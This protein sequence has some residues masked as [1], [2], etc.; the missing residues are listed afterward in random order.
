MVVAVSEDALVTKADRT[1]RRILDAAAEVFLARGY[2]G[3]GLRDIA[4]AAKMQAGSLYYHFASRDELV[5][6]VLRVGQDLISQAV[7]ERLTELLPGANDL[8]RLRAVMRAHVESLAAEGKYT[9][10]AMRLLGTVPPEIHQQQLDAARSYGNLWRDLIAAAQSSGVVRPDL[11]PG[12]MRMFIIGALNSI[13][14]WYQLDRLTLTGGRLAD[15]FTTV[16]IDGLATAYRPH[17]HVDVPQVGEP[18]SASKSQTRG[19]TTRSRI[20]ACGADAFREKGFNDTA[21]IDVAEAAGLQRGSLYYHFTSR[22]ALAE[23]LLRDAWTRT[24]NLV[25]RAVDRL[26]AD[27]YPIDRLETAI[28]AHLLSQLSE[29]GYTAGLVH[30]LA[31]VPQD[32]RRQSLR[33]ERSYMNY[34]RGLVSDAIAAGDVRAGPHPRTA[35]LILIS[36][37]N[38]SIEWFE[39]S[40]GLTPQQLADQMLTLVLDGLGTGAA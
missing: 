40:G 33:R 8:D 25:R 27:A 21:F 22:E 24:A 38:W 7:S 11:S 9:A 2:G 31:R 23:Q 37:L 6:E 4:A 26:P 17:R 34:W 5:T 36:A 13:P 29:T 19:A 39:P 1:R 15:E 12:A 18:V 10:A 16:F 20:L 14:D 3:A 30:V 32:V 28:T 35:V